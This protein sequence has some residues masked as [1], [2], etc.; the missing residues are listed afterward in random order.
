MSI[1]EKLQKN[2]T[3]KEGAIKDRKH[4]R[5]TKEIIK[6]SKKTEEIKRMQNIIVPSAKQTQ[7]FTK[8]PSI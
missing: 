6:E 5:I 2:Y 4:M 8:R 3:G 1:K 7:N